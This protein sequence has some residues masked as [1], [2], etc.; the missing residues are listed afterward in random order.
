VLLYFAVITPAIGQRI[1]DTSTGSLFAGIRTERSWIDD[2]LPDGA[3][4]AAVWTGQATPYTIWENEFFNRSVGDVYYTAEPLPG[5]LPE[6]PLA[7]DPASGLLSAG[8]EALES[9]YAL[10]DGSFPLVGSVVARDPGTGM[11][12]YRTH[13]QLRLA[14]RIS[15]IYPSDNWS[16]GEVTYTRLRCDGGNLRV[17]LTSDPNLFRSSQ[18][19]TAFVGGKAVARTALLP[20]SVDVPLVVPLRP[21]GGACVA[22]FTISPT[23]V[24]DD[25]IGNGDTRALGT[26]FTSFVYTP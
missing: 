26:H 1:R 9:E 6:T 7:V 8:G 16:G 20:N 12:V 21:S 3:E 2:A 25:V 4:A 22:R 14:A 18:L 11:T 15:G 10:A 24:P 23:A 5:N 19:V 13:G 17:T